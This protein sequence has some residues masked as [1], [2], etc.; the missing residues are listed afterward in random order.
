MMA[1]PRNLEELTYKEISKV[2]KSNIR[3]K[4]RLV[5][6]ERTKFLET[7]QHPG[8]SIVQFIHWLK[9]RAWYFEFERLGTDEMTT[10]DEFIML[11]LID[12]MHDPAFEHKL[13]E[14]LQSV[15]LTV[16]T[17]IE[18]VQQLELIKKYNQQLNEGEAYST[19]KYKISCQY[20]G[21]RHVRVKNNCPTFGKTCSICKRKNHAPKVCRY[22][23]KLRNLKTHKWI[24]ERL[25]F[26]C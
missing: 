20:C 8:E 10:E 19:N 13:L 16:E 25:K 23:R 5:I 7:R 6:M 1:Y 12:G 11:H 24:E 2:I 26:S 4:K 9:E 14:I 15:N 3:Q 17:C 21:E 22:K 18:F